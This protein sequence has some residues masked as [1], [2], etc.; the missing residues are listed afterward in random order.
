[1][2]TPINLTGISM[3]RWSAGGCQLLAPPLAAA[4]GTVFQPVFHAV[5][6]GPWPP[7]WT[8]GLQ[9]GP[10]PTWHFGLAG[11]GEP[12]HE[13]APQ[14][15]NTSGSHG[16]G[17]SPGMGGLGGSS[18]KATRLEAGDAGEQA[19]VWLGVAQRTPHFLQSLPVLT[20]KM[21]FRL[22]SVS[23]EI[24]FA[25]GIPVHPG[26][27][28]S[29]HHPP[30]WDR[31]SLGGW[32]RCQ[33]HHHSANDSSHGS[34]HGAASHLAMVPVLHLVETGC[35][36]LYTWGHTWGNSGALLPPL[37]LSLSSRSCPGRS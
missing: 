1:M 19:G 17:D 2:G 29:P 3:V 24:S 11:V 7:E 5:S 20:E 33:A 6:C 16:F 27:E 25:K 12:G 36:L 35:V 18:Q 21:R 32:E 22:S 23:G 15:S 4:R 10:A 30:F 34:R 8:P 37:G 31:P 28:R 14:Q 9:G 26:S 13:T